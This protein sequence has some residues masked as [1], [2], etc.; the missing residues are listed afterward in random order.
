M[1]TNLSNIHALELRTMKILYSFKNP[2]HHG[3]P[4]CFCVDRRKIW[5]AVGTTHGIID[6]YDLRFRIR[7]KAWGLP[8]SI[9]IHRIMLHPTK[10]RGKWITVA[11][12][13]GQGE[14]TVWD[15]EKVS[16]SGQA[17]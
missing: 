4:T 10:G 11:G 8:G 15:V 9:A 6:M 1:A 3:T 16:E 14:V 5:L 13:S 12:G 2:L 17:V 7:V